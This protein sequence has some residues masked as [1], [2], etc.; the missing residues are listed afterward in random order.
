MVVPPKYSWFRLLFVWK[1][2]IIEK[3]Y[4]RLIGLFLFCCVIVY[5]RGEIFDYKIALNPTPFSLIGVAVAIFLGFRNSAS[6]DRFWEGRKL[7]GA[8]VR[9]NR[10]LARQVTTLTGLPMQSTEL[11]AFIHLQ[12]AFVYALKHQLRST[13]PRPDLERNL[14]ESLVTQVMQARFKPIFLLREMGFWLQEQ[15]LA[16]KLDSITLTT[17]D[18]TLNQLS[19][20]VTGCERLV[21]TPIPYTYNVLLHRTVYIYGLLLPFGLVDSLG[22]M[23][24]VIVVF[25]GYTFIAVDAIGSEI[26]EPFGTEP[27]D[28]PLNAMCQI[29]EASV[30]ETIG[31]NL[32]VNTSFSSKLIVD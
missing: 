15:R 1:G 31:I 24:P 7:W 25:I 13:D 2:S 21:N 6:Y 26:E 8:L 30:L 19:A 10:S 28:L 20:I 14:P 18:H 5:L 12:I 4:P 3:I 11:S 32:P 17:I 29:I 23:T 22:W 16:G 9:E 27:N